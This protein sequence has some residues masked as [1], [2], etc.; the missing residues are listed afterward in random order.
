MIKPAV[1][2]TKNRYSQIFSETQSLTDPRSAV[3]ALDGRPNS[4]SVDESFHNPSTPNGD[5]LRTL[6]FSVLSSLWYKNKNLKQ[7][8]KKTLDAFVQRQAEESIC[9]F[10][11]THYDHVD[12]AIGCVKH[13]IEI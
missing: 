12:E 6:L 4:L 7:M 11:R 1:S 13:H 8:P 5:I 3:Y 2:D 9:Q 10:C